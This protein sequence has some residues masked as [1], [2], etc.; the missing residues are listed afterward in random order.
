MIYR[1]APAGA[2]KRLAFGTARLEEVI[3]YTLRLFTRPNTRSCADIK[4][5]RLC[6]QLLVAREARF[7]FGVIKA[8][9]IG[10]PKRRQG[11]RWLS[12]AV[13][14]P[15]SDKLLELSHRLFGVAIVLRFRFYGRRVSLAA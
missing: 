2:R 10:I 12:L 14:G 15:V 9:I 4:V 1:P 6:I 3:P 7:R 5:Q 8:S 11:R 13:C